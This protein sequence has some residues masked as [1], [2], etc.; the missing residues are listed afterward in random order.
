MVLRWRLLEPVFNN[1]ANGAY[2]MTTLIRKLT[3]SIAV[4]NP[5]FEPNELACILVWAVLPEKWTMTLM[6]KPALLFSRTPPISFYSGRTATWTMFFSSI[7]LDLWN[8][9]TLVSKSS[10][11]KATSLSLRQHFLN[12]IPIARSRATKQSRIHGVR[13]P[14]SPAEAGSLAMTW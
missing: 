9:L 7:S 8:V 13:L 5:M 11:I 4:Y 2:T 14:R 3:E 6:T 12:I 10:T 1:A